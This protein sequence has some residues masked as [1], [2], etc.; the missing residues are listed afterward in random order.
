M[1]R[2]FTISPF[3]K[4]TAAYRIRRYLDRAEELRIIAQDMCDAECRRILLGLP[5]SYEQMA[6][7]DQC[8][9]TPAAIN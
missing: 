2:P 7:A 6:E 3:S 8:R 5:V 9:A 4:G 1:E